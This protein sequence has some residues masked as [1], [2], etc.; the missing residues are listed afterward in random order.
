MCKLELYIIE[1]CRIKQKPLFLQSN[2]LKS[3]TYRLKTDCSEISNIEYIVKMGFDGIILKEQI[4]Q[5]PN[6]LENIKFLKEKIIENEAINEIKTK[7]EELSKFYS[8][9]NEGMI[10][11]NIES[12]FDNAVKF[13]FENPIKLI[14]LKS[15]NYEFAKSV[16]KYRPN[17]MIVF[18]T[19]DK[20]IYDYL[21]LLRGI[22]PFIR[23][24]FEDCEECN[25][26]FYHE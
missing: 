14:I 16:S 12:I 5:D 15:N 11:K 6:Y 3:L 17:C 8:S 20:I 24:N 9:N 2:I 21:R 4:T 22:I 23:N 13:S 10:D 26:H 19:N 1:L 7:Y 25:F 18:I